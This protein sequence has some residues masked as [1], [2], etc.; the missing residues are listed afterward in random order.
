[1]R[2]GQVAA[3]SLKVNFLVQGVTGKGHPKVV[4]DGKCSVSHCVEVS[5]IGGRGE[6]ERLTD[7]RVNDREVMA[8]SD[9]VAVKVDE[10]M[11]ADAVEMELKLMDGRTV[12]KHVEHALGSLKNPL[13]DAQL[14]EKFSRLC[15]GILKPAQ[16]RR[17]IEQCHALGDLPDVG[18]I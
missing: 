12:A 4:V 10:S 9:K 11:P 8:L 14:D 17:L 5:S 6:E 13:S 15:E 1:I 3:V 16:I 2:P 18:E 7:A